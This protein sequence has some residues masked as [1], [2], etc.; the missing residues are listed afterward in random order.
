M[1]SIPTYLMKTKLIL[2]VSILY[3]ILLV[4]DS[5]GQWMQTA[6][7]IT[8]FTTC[9]I[10]KDGYI[11]AGSPYYGVFR[12]SDHG[13]NWIN[14]NADS[15]PG[16]STIRNV[17]AFT[18]LGKY[19]FVA[20]QSAGVFRS[21]ND[22]KNWTEVDSGLNN[23]AVTSLVVFNGNLFVGTEGIPG[24]DGVWRSIDSGSSWNLVG[25]GDYEIHTLTVNGNVLF[26]GTSGGIF[27]STD[28]GANWTAV[29]TGIPRLYIPSMTSAYGNVFAVSFGAGVFKSTN[30]GDSWKPANRGFGNNKVGLIA[31]VDKDLFAAGVGAFRSTDSGSTWTPINRGLTNSAVQAFGYDGTY[32]FAGTMGNVNG[33]K[34][35]GIYRS[36][37]DDI[38]WSIQNTGLHYS[39]ITMLASCNGSLFAGAFSFF[40]MGLYRT[41][42]TGMVWIESD[43]GLPP[44]P[45]HALITAQSNLFVGTSNGVYKS[46]DQGISWSS[47]NNGLREQSIYSFA[48]NSNNIFAATDQGIFVSANNGASW[49]STDSNFT[50][51]IQVFTVNN[52]NLFAAAEDSLYR[53]MDNGRSWEAINFGLGIWNVYAIASLN[54][55][56]FAG[57]IGKGI[58]RSTD[59]GTHWENVSNGLKDS[60]IVSFVTA[61]SNIFAGTGAG[62]WL[63]KDYGENWSQVST[64]LITYHLAI[65]DSNLF[66]GTGF[67]TGVWRRPLSDFGINTVKE[68]SQPDLNISISPNPTTGIIFVHNAPANILHVTV[69][70]ILGESVLELEHP[71]APDFTL[72]LSKFPPGIYFAKFSSSSGVVTE[73]VVKN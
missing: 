14:I 28:N 65:N 12:S 36:A 16:P 49:V 47:S 22:G 8:D 59:G 33:F 24:P 40:D 4:H 60:S 43:S 27:R 46:T 39:D 6:G 3:L 45:I 72:D 25:L 67:G 48:T 42:G 1:D 11:F 53:S 64:E 55:K 30:N 31:F 20:S 38:N 61:G 41:T 29:N 56:V 10:A 15:I 26:A 18:I 35:G 37:T 63:S 58:F 17:S 62:I 73:K 32:F 50:K 34:G 57:T 68:N 69:S 52:G 23:T 51:T 44:S 70:S 7:P 21:T 9:F 71:N 5:T 66:A 13:T 19:L 54:E 2:F